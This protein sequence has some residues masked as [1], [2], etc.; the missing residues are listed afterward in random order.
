MRNLLRRPGFWTA[1]G[2]L[3][4]TAIVMILRARGPVVRTVLAE[5]RNLEQHIVASGRVRVPTRVQIAAQLS[6]LVVAVGAVEGQRVTAGD[7]LVQLDDSTERASVAQAEAAVK[8]AQAR[9]DQLRRVGAIV[10][11]ES[12]RQTDTNLAKAQLELERTAKLAKSGAVPV[13]EL[14]NAQRAVDIAQAQKNAAQA[15]QV[16]SAPMGA[17]SRV[18]LTALLQA[19]AQLTGAKARLAQ[20]RIVALQSGTVLAREVEPGDVVQP[21]RMLLELAADSDVEL[22]FDPDER[23][24]AWIRIGQLAKASADAFPQQVFDAKVSYIAPAVDPQ[25]GSV[26]IQLDVPKPPAFLKPDMTVSI[27]L[28]IAAKQQVLTVPSV[29]VHGAATATPWLQIVQN[30][31][32]V[33][34]DV[35]LGIRGEGQV[36]IEAGLEAGSEVIV[37]DGRQL[38]AGARVRTER[39]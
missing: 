36:E 27:D 7:L 19:Q 4:A 2:L 15:Q 24:L 17:D 5:R 30:D 16:A 33:R 29:V 10:A 28:T 6:G 35:K 18:A 1:V 37:P 20:T 14:E 22:V 26:E 31:R 8:Q 9:V 3:V 21:S 34:R 39:D 32:V 25:R 38:A 11:T 23:N 13:V 12:L